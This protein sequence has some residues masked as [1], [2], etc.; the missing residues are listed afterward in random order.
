MNKLPIVFVGTFVGGISLILTSDSG[1]ITN[2][3]S[4]NLAGAM[5]SFFSG[6]YLALILYFHFKNH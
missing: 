2:Y 1:H 6:I 3:F 5:V 4:A